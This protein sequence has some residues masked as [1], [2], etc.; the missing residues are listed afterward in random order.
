MVEAAVVFQ[1]V[2]PAQAADPRTLRLSF[3]TLAPDDIANGVAEDLVL[4]ERYDPSLPPTWGD[5][6]LLIQIFLNLVKNAAE[7]WLNGENLGVAWSAPFRFDLTKCVKSSGNKLEVKVVNLWCNRLAGD[8]R[9]PKGQQITKTNVPIDPKVE[10]LESGLI[11]PVR[12]LI[13]P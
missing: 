10:P 13:A 1:A 11:G 9:L 8:A 12:L 2:V 4:K 3:V 6:D 7:V 5:E